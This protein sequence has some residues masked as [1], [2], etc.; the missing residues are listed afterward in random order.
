MRASRSARAPELVLA[1]VMAVGL[2]LAPLFTGDAAA[3]V[4]V[5]KAALPDEIG[6]EIMGSIRLPAVNAD[7]LRPSQP[8]GPTAATP[9]GPLWIKWRALAADLARD[10]AVLAHCREDV[11]TCPAEALRLIATIDAARAKSGRAQ[12]GEVN[13]AVNLAIRPV[14]DLAQH[15]VADRWTAPLATFAS[16]RGDC[17][18][19]AIAKYVALQEAGV[20]ENDLRLLIVRDQRAGDH[21]VL[22]VRQGTRWLVLDNRHLNLVDAADVPNFVPLYALGADG[23][24]TFAM[25]QLRRTAQVAAQ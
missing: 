1:A 22:A 4:D 9:E 5:A 20:A 7:E 21:A 14:T 19:Y 12:I 16:G 3:N 15:G 8:S 10:T 23:V 6:Q 2:A 24:Q 11:T 17:E 18:D 25:A 13:R